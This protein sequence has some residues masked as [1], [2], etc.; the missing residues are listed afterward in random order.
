MF[1]VAVRY[2]DKERKIKWDKGVLSGD[3]ALVLFVKME[4]NSLEGIPVGPGEGPFT[5]RDHL[6]DPLSTLMIIVRGF[7]PIIDSTGDLPRRA[8]VPEGVIP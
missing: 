6:K 5:M 1:T 3:P 4:A 2:L 7:G 8:D